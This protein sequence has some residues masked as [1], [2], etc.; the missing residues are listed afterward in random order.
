MGPN[1][2]PKIKA[3]LHNELVTEITRRILSAGMMGGFSSPE[4]MVVLESI[5]V[6]VVLGMEK[7]MGDPIMIDA[8]MQ[9]AKVRI[10]DAHRQGFGA[11]K[12]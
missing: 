2:L 9:R 3:D 5:V 6:G 8:L 7:L 4:T 10:A 1:D 12:Q 11:G